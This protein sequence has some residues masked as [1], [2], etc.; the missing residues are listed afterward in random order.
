ML[1]QKLP[2]PA[3]TGTHLVCLNATQFFLKKKLDHTLMKLNLQHMPLKWSFIKDIKAVEQLPAKDF[4][5]FK[6]SYLFSD[7]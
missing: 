2:T 4:F 6:I 5:F 1:L 7:I 3:L